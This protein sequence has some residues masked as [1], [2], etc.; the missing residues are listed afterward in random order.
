MMGW[1]VGVNSNV[2]IPKFFNEIH[3]IEK[4]IG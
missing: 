2:V 3:G 1:G 4:T